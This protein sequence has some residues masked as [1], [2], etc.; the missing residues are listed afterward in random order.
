MKNIIRTIKL[1][2]LVNSN[3]S[4]SLLEITKLCHEN[5]FCNFLIKTFCNI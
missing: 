4:V 5:K 3:K 2:I 1:I